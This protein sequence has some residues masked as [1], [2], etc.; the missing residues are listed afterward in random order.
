MAT[1]PISTW[2]TT[3][4][5]NWGYTPVHTAVPSI[6]AILRDLAGQSSIDHITIV[7]HANPDLMQIQFIDGGPA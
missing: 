7:S 4:Y 3:F 2:P 5:D 1:S 6:E